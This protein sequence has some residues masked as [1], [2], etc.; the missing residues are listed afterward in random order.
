MSPSDELTTCAAV[1]DRIE[2]FTDGDLDK[3][4]VRRVRQH[5]DQCAS[6]AKQAE[7]ARTLTAELRA[8]PKLDLPDR[9]M[10]AVRAEVG[11]PADKR[12]ADP[13]KRFRRPWLAAAAASILVIAGTLFIHQ[14]QGR[15]SDRE[16]L[17]AAAEIEYALACVGEI[18]RRA[19]RTATARVMNGTAVSSAFD[20]VTRTLDQSSRL[21]PTVVQPTDSQPSEGSS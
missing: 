10:D 20:G 6:C 12:I 7:L 15:Q 14:Q 11:I 3:A 2:A 18:T 5:L 21:L 19:N 16:A 8:L 4:T 9:V 13:P 17:R 1:T